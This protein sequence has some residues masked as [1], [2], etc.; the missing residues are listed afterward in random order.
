MSE[1]EPVVC[2]KFMRK[3]NAMRAAMTAALC[4]LVIMVA[5][6]ANI[7][8]AQ[9]DGPWCAFYE[10]LEA[11][12]CGFHTYEQ[13]LAAVSGAGGYCEPNTMYVPPSGTG[14]TLLARHHRHRVYR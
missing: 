14:K 9:A 1:R 13:C 4:F 10:A 2:L 12:N 3:E 5:T 8:P 7:T 6:S 11:T